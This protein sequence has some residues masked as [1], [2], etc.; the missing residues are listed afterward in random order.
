MTDFEQA[1]IKAFKHHF[2]QSQLLGCFFHYAQCSWRKFCE[3]GLKVEYKNKELKIWFRKLVALPLEPPET[4]DDLFLD[5]L[6]NRDQMY[7]NDD[8]IYLKVENMLD[9]MTLTWVDDLFSYSL[10]NQ[11]KSKNKQSCGRLQYWFKQV[12]KYPPKYIQVN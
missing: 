9:Y 4:I 8:P 12:T 2:P 7:K 10:W 1:A 11:F 5:L 6:D 3:L